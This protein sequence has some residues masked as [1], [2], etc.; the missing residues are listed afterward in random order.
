MEKQKTYYKNVRVFN[1]SWIKVRGKLWKVG[2][3]MA[4]NRMKKSVLPTFCILGVTYY[5]EYIAHH[6]WCRWEVPLRYQS[7]DYVDMEVLIKEYSDGSGRL[8]VAKFRFL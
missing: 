1:H 5:D 6:L 4:W 3:K 2:G 8:G 7:G